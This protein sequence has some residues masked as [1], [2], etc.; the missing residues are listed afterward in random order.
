MQSTPKGAYEENFYAYKRAKSGC[1]CAWRHSWGRYYLPAIPEPIW[2]ELIYV[3]SAQTACIT[4]HVPQSHICLMHVQHCASAWTK[5]RSNIPELALVS[6]SPMFLCPYRVIFGKDFILSKTDCCKSSV[7][8]RITVCRFKLLRWHNITPV[9]ILHMDWFLNLWLVPSRPP[10]RSPWRC[11]EHGAR[12]FAPLAFLCL[13]AAKV[14]NA[15]NKLEH[16]PCVVLFVCL[17][18]F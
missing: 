9:G 2:S 15:G 4:E 10:Q 14:R 6:V 18:W 17:C 13:R 1:M 5:H 11:P 16:E 7:C 12:C 3:A 8:L